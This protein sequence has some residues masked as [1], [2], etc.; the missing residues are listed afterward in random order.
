MIVQT[1]PKPLKFHPK[2][3]S[4]CS[5]ATRLRDAV[6]FFLDSNWQSY[7]DREKLREIRPKIIFDYDETHVYVKPR[8]LEVEVEKNSTVVTIKCSN[9]SLEEVLAFAL[10]IT[11]RRIK[12]QIIFSDLSPSIIPKVHAKL[13]SNPLL[14]FFEDDSEWILI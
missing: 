14:Q 13:E 6:R 11:N 4:T 12:A 1:F 7:V 9:P 5:I 3:S 8:F 2:N 10:L